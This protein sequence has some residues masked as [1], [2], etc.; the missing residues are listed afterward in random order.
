[1]KK[2]NVQTWKN[3]SKSNAH[4]IGSQVIELKSK[5]NLFACCLIVAKSRR[6]I[7]VR[8]SLGKY[9]FSSYSRS[10]FDN[11]GV[12]LPTVGKSKLIGGLEECAKQTQAAS[13]H[14]SDNPAMNDGSNDQE[15]THKN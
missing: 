5:Q 3:T 8:E 11:N 14:T 13:D 15:K 9:K 12:L 10:L 6:E 4:K 2:M 7:D 1:M